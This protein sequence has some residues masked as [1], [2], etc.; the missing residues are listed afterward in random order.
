MYHQTN[1]F[2]SEERM[3]TFSTVLAAQPT[4]TWYQ[5]QKTKL[6]PLVLANQ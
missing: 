6:I 2:D 4:S 5:Y 3:S 1:N